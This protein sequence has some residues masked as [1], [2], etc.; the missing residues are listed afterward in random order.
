MILM[1]VVWMN[2]CWGRKTKKKAGWSWRGSC[3]LMMRRKEK[4]MSWEMVF[5]DD[6][7]DDREEDE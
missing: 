4:M 6:D 3:C 1:V 5:D 7:D 2:R